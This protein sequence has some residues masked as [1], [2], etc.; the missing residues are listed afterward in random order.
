MGHFVDVFLFKCF[1]RSRY[2]IDPKIQL[3]DSFLRD[4]NHTFNALP[5]IKWWMVPFISARKENSLSAELCS[6]L[7]WEHLK[8]RTWFETEN[9]SDHWNL[10]W[11]PL[12]IDYMIV[13][14]HQAQQPIE[15]RLHIYAGQANSDPSLD[16]SLPGLW[17]LKQNNGSVSPVQSLTPLCWSQPKARESHA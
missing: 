5:E 4:E 3:S 15:W 1:N 2:S 13:F 12:F 6:L 9:I 16:W 11:F 17:P 14:I 10:R 8:S 7:A